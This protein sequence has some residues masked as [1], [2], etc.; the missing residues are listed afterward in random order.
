MTCGDRVRSVGGGYGGATVAWRG[1][2]KMRVGRG[3]PRPASLHGVVFVSRGFAVLW[4]QVTP[5]WCLLNV[6]MVTWHD[7]GSRHRR[8]TGSSIS[9]FSLAPETLPPSIS[10]GSFIIL[11][12]QLQLNPSLFPP[13]L[14]PS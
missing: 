8:G 4:W 7:R 1:G 5:W 2:R 11:S 3:A 6:V 14:R 12:P 13:S 9:L 10:P